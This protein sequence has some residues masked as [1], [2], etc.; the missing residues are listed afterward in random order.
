MATIAQHEEPHLR[1]DCRRLREFYE[2]HLAQPLGYALLLT[3]VGTPLLV[4]TRWVGF[5]S[6]YWLH[7]VNS[8]ADAL[9][10]APAAAAVCFLVTF[11]GFIVFRVRL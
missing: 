6:W 11:L 5:E 10:A 8:F 2:E 1:V 4:L 9:M 7:P 3:A